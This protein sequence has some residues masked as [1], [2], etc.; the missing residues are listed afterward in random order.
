MEGS[1]RAEWGESA[2]VLTEI[3]CMGDPDRGLSCM[4]YSSF[5]YGQIRQKCSTVSLDR[6]QLNGLNGVKAVENVITAYIVNFYSNLTQPSV[7]KTALE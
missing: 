7:H 3:D 1:S 2:E 5:F 4:L 6:S